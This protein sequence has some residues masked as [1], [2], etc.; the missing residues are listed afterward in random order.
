MIVTLDD[1][2]VALEKAPLG[3]LVLQKGRIAWL[4]EILTDI[5]NR[6]K[7]DLVGRLLNETPLANLP[8][9]SVAEMTVDDRVL[10]L[11]HRQAHKLEGREIHYFADVTGRIELENDIERL[12][13]RVHSLETKD[14][15]TGLHNRRAILQEL[16]RQI[17]RSR[18]YQNP[19]SIIRLGIDCHTGEEQRIAMIQ[20]I[21]RSLKDKLRWADEIGMLND[22]AFLLILPETSLEDAKELAVKLLSDRATFDFSDGENKIRYGVASWQKGDDLNKLLRRVEE[23]REINLSALLS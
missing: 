9:D 2:S 21:G 20:T 16:D 18:R 11:E 14:P 8:M 4:N 12:Q 10:W 1:L 22:H 19:L 7:G 6:P 3:V 23:D 5:A 13:Q 17:S 15:V